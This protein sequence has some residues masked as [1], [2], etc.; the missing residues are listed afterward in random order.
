MS[1][2]KT[3]ESYLFVIFMLCWL[4]VSVPSQANVKAYHV[5]ETNGFI[6]V[7]YHAEGIE[8]TWKP[9]EIEEITKGEW[10]YRGR[11][12][13]YVNAHIEVSSYW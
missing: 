4:H 3:T 7:W 13:H 5:I 9:P 12:E 11:T 8:P 10:S 6:Y 2:C 1:E